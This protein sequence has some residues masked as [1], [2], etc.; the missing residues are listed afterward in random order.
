MKHFR[1]KLATTTL[2]LALSVISWPVVAQTA[3]TAIFVGDSNTRG[4]NGQQSFREELDARLAASGCSLISRGIDSSGGYQA[5]GPH[6]GHSGHRAE[7]F[8][9]DTQNGEA[10]RGNNRG[11]RAIMDAESPRSRPVDAVILNVGTNDIRQG[12]SV[13]GTLNE[14]TEIVDIIQAKSPTTRI[15]LGNVLPWYHRDSDGDG[16]LD[17]PNPQTDAL[18]DAL[19]AEYLDSNVP[20]VHLVDLRTGFRPTDMVDGIHASA[21]A[22]NAPFSDAGEHK[23]AVA[24]ASALESEGVCNPRLPD[25]SFPL[26]DILSPAIADGDTL[27]GPI[28]LLGKATDTGGAGF[29]RVEVG[30]QNDSGRW[31]N[32]ATGTFTRNAR[33]IN[34]H[35][36]QTSNH[37]TMWR[38][39]FGDPGPGGAMISLPDDEYT[40]FA[41]AT[42]RNGNQNFS[43]NPGAGQWPERIRFTIRNGGNTTGGGTTGGNTGGNT[44]GGSLFREAEDGSLSGAMAVVNNNSAS[45]SQ[46]VNVPANRN[47]N[48][49]SDFVE[50]SINIATPGTYQI[51]ARV[52]GPSGS[53][54]SFFAQIN[55]GDTYLWDIPKDNTFT[56]DLISD[57]GNGNVSEALSAG[58]HTLR[59]SFREAGAQLDWIEFERQ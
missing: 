52:R 44:G 24:F 20:G 38:V 48:S 4:F 13:R 57:R 36:F 33:S 39:G 53:Q 35:L 31:L 50:F 45:N 49:N 59:I 42:D 14:V 32:F 7:H 51:N 54:N 26:T 11:I 6:E 22:N 23:A 29:D 37:S 8:L 55:N 40:L 41:L 25:S 3:I 12:Q 47:G 5:A 46:L 27:S 15:F 18:S 19:E 2:T 28:S 1:T 9:R 17:V 30:I 34:A 10:M 56:E 16:T 21:N 58:T 43:G